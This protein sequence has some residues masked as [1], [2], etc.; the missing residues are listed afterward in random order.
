MKKIL[1]AT[2]LSS[3]ASFAYADTKAYVEDAVVW[4]DSKDTSQVIYDLIY[5]GR[6]GDIY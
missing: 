5:D 4:F 1:I 2:M 3:I 6:N